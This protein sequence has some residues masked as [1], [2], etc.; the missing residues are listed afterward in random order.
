M[1]PV[2][3]IFVNFTAAL[4]PVSLA[5]DV[6]GRLRKAASLRDTAFWTLLAGTVATPITIAA[7]WYW[8]GQMDQIDWHTDTVMKV[9]AW[10]GSAMG[11]L[12]LALVGW[13]FVEFRRQRHPTWAYIGLLMLTVGALVA[14]GHLGGVHAFGDGDAEAPP[15]K[16]ASL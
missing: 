11:A 4:I 7:G 8:A 12:L 10:L 5:S 3:P 15:A 6:L 2:H 14:Q 13:R 1:P 16:T 9:H